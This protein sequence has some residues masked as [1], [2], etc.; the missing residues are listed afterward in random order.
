L[1]VD[2]AVETRSFKEPRGCW[3][4]GVILVVVVVVVVKR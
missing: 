4:L 2:R 1:V 3:M